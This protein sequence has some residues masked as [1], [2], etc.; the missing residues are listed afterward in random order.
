[1]LDGLDFARMT[2]S[3]ICAH[4]KKSCCPALKELEKQI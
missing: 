3:Q 2:M 4:L 1:M